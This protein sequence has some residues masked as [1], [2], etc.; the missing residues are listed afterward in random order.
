MV[1]KGLFALSIIVATAYSG[2]IDD[3]DALFNDN[4]QQEPKKEQSNS[5]GDIDDLDSMF[6]D[7]MEE[8]KKEKKKKKSYSLKMSGFFKTRGYGFLRKTHYEGKNNSQFQDD[9]ILEVDSKLKKGNYLLTTSIFGIIG[10]EHNTYNYRETLHEFRDVNKE[11]PMGG[12]REFYLLRTGENLDITVGKRIFK[13]GISTIYSPSDV[14]NYTLAPDPLDPYTL[15][16]WLVDFEYYRGDSSYGFIFFPF[17]S[18]SKSFSLKSRWSGTA[19]KNKQISNNFIVPEGS[20]IKE[21]GENKVRALFRYKTNQIILGQGL[22]FIFDIGAGPSLYT[23]LVYTDKENTYLETRPYGWYVSTGFSTT[24]KKL[25]VHGEVYY[26]N[27]Y[28]DKDDDFISAVG[29]ATYTLD[30]WVDKVGFDKINMTMEYVREIIVDSYNPDITYRSSENERAPKNDILINISAEVND[31]VSFNYFA[32]FRLSI[33]QNKDS[34]RYQKLSTQYK[35]KDGLLTNFFVELFNGDVN[36]YYGKWREN[37]RIGID[38]KY[39][40]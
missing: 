11:V 29:G 36:S 16:I 9:S 34:G 5:G 21:D 39:Y 12:I 7:T 40:F 17:I 30:K 27:A 28:M 22:D 3:P 35:V 20:E 26:Q 25:E 15:G 24:Y 38:L 23:V 1:K 6:A 8:P 32:N 10:T 31:K 33:K 14:Y 4:F 2:D 18:N 37:D 13:N 19:D